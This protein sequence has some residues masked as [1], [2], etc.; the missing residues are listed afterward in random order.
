VVGNDEQWQEARPVSAKSA[1]DAR[2]VVWRRPCADAVR[3]EVGIRWNESF[4]SRTTPSYVRGDM[5]APV[6]VRAVTRS[7]DR[8]H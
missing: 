5:V 8:R 4:G 2:N 7:R 3:A 6:A 1:T